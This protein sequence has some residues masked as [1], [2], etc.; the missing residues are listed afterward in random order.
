MSTCGIYSVSKEVMKLSFGV[1]SMLKEIEFV[2]ELS[3]RNPRMKYYYLQGWNDKNKKLSCKANYSPVEFYCPC[4]VE[5][6]VQDLTQVD[7]S[8][9]EYIRKKLR[10]RAGSLI[11]DES[12]A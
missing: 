1:Y 2:Q 12:K 4:I 3:K 10:E 9:T 6:W 11:L 5:G 7:S 8:R